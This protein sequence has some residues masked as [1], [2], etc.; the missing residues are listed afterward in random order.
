[1]AKWRLFNQ[2]F[3]G[4]GAFMGIVW[5]NLEQQDPKHLLQ[6]REPKYS[7]IKEALSISRQGRKATR[8]ARPP[9]QAK[10]KRDVRLK[11]G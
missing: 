10:T 5:C 11:S 3:N 6:E 1:M 7:Q 9:T 4:F 8:V 2:I